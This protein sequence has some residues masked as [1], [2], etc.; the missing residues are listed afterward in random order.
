MNKLSAE[1]IYS[2][3]ELRPHPEGGAFVETFRDLQPHDRRGRS[4]AIYYLLKSGERSNWHRID[5]VEIWH[6]TL[7]RQ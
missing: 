7:V 2:L 5:A 4:S 1:E 3:L 6:F